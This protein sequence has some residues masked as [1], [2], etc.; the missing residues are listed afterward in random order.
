MLKSFDSLLIWCDL[1]QQK[2]QEK[3]FLLDPWA[4]KFYKDPLG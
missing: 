3:L 1:L 4:L 2:Q